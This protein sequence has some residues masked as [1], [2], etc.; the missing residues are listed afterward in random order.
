MKVSLNYLILVTLFAT[1]PLPAHAVYRCEPNLLEVMFA[2]DSMVRLRDGALIDL[3]GKGALQ[4]VNQVL[5]KAGTVE[6][7]RGIAVPEADLDRLHQLAEARSGEG[8]YN[9]NNIFRLRT[10]GRADVWKLARELE[11]LKGVHSARPVPLP[12]RPPDPMD[13]EPYQLYMNS[14][15]N[16]VPGIGGFIAWSYA[17]GTGADVRVCDIEYGWNMDH[18]D[19]GQLPGSSVN[20]SHESWGDEDFVNHGT[21][22]A[23]LLAADDNGWGTTGICYDAELL[24]SCAIDGSESWNVPAAMAWATISLGPGDVILLEQQWD[25]DGG[26]PD[27]QDGCV[28]IEWWTNESPGD[29]TY[30]AVYAAIR[31]AVALGIHVVEAAGNGNVDLDTLNWHGDSGA[32]IVGAGG[33]SDGGSYPET[34][35]QRLPFSSYGARVDVQG[36]GENVVTTGYGDLYSDWGP[37]YYYTNV[38]SGTSGA[39]AVI[40]GAVACCSGYFQNGLHSNPEY[41]TPEEVRT[42][43]IE[44]ST[45]QITPPAGHIGGLPDLNRIFDAMEPMGGIGCVN[46]GD[47]NNDF[48]VTA[49]DAR[50]AFLTAIGVYE[51]NNE[52][53]CAAD[54]NGDGIVTA[55]DALGIFESALGRGSCLMSSFEYVP[56]GSFYMGAPPDEPCGDQDDE[57]PVHRISLTHGFYIQTTEV[58]QSQWMDIFGQNPA[59]YYGLNRPVETVSWYDCLNYCNQRSL[60]EGYRPCYYVDA[61]FTEIYESGSSVYWD[62]TAD[63]F[64]LPTEAEWE[65]ACR[66]GTSTSLNN[67]TE[68]TVC[69]GS[70]PNL[71]LLGRYSNNGGSTDH[72]TT[73]GSYQPNAWGLYDMHGNV[74]EWCWDWY[75]EDYYGFSPDLNP[76]G[77][78][79]GSSRVVRGGA[80]YYDPRYCR[81]ASRTSSGPAP[82]TFL[83]ASVQ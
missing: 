55:G 83:S 8:Q 13:Y 38:F 10:D 24:T 54:C 19:I 81:S 5:A 48:R 76:T 42:L 47:V 77:A 79:F 67:G 33:V 14:S 63:G 73:V 46:N 45:N 30:N 74:Y 72:H 25:Y 31:Q 17:G 60:S 59:Y 78:S 68:V 4:G 41:L 56:P 61:E 1:F 39:S 40:A 21:A 6:W 65:Y 37:D 50:L 71:N 34:A 62:Q 9:M 36:H 70:D 2:Q 35:Q 64:R 15:T 51:V 26:D 23:G 82:L 80:C 43:L 29:Q 49:G 20:P 57:V 32:I 3:S 66:G 53:F 28:P 58:T 44:N 11:A 22:A 16:S 52:E 7:R 12:V 27:S 75:D 69:S 18:E